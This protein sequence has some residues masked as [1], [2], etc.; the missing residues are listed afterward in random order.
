MADSGPLKGAGKI[1]VGVDLG[2]AYLVVTVL[3]EANQPL[4][5][6]MTFAQVVRD[7]VVV[8]YW[9]AVEGVR[10]LKEEIEKKTGLQLGRAATAIPPGTGMAT[11]K[12]HAYV[13]E[14]AGLEVT[15][16]VDEPTAA[17]QVLGVV[18]GAVV[19]IG[20]GTTGVAVF[21][22][23]E[24]V[25]VADEPTGGTHIS[26]VLSGRYGL[27]FTEAE[28]MKLDPARRREVMAAATP[29]IEKM[30]TIVR[31]HIRRAGVPVEAVYL[32]GGTSCLAG[33]EDI[34]AR[35]TELP[36]YKPKNPLLVTPLG[37]AMCS[38]T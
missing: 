36:V 18:N 30:G 21:H 33:A 12:S 28:K 14:T 31:E 11:H 32:V 20:G 8:D 38:Q 24:V 16:V 34:I 3:D 37:I 35:E 23:G 22:G 7:G 13:V 10:A 5:G 19:D 29:V 25:Y 2:T 1:K 26:L 17:N 27:S 15:T 4:A 6:A 9:G